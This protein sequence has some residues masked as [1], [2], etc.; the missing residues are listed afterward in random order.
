MET[1]SNASCYR[2]C[3]DVVF[4]LSC[5][6]FD[7]LLNSTRSLPISKVVNMALYGSQNPYPY[8]AQLWS[9][10]QLAIVVC[11]IVEQLRNCVGIERRT[12]A[13]DTRRIQRIEYRLTLIACG[14]KIR[15]RTRYTA[16]RNDNA[17]VAVLAAIR[18]YPS[19]TV[20]L[21]AQ[22]TVLMAICY[23]H[24]GHVPKEDV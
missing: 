21:G 9:I 18:Q 10:R 3:I 12:F 2:I 8:L 11:A 14:R 17:E 22:I 15:R 20:R 5:N 1:N 16:V 6:L 7:M 13:K 19:V 23:W 4:Q 24:Y